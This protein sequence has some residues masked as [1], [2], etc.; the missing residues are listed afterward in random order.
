V[1]AAWSSRLLCEVSP[2]KAGPVY[3]QSLNTGPERIYGVMDIFYTQQYINII[4]S[5]FFSLRVTV[6]VRVSGRVRASDSF[7]ILSQFMTIV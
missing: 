7:V 6:R 1:C 5:I 2:H 3:S 4:Y